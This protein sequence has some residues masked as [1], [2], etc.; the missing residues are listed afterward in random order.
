MFLGK[1]EGPFL[2]LRKETKDE[3]IKMGY[4]EKKIIIMEDIENDETDLSLDDKFRRI[5]KRH[6]PH[7]FI[8]FFPKGQRMD[9]V[10]FELGWLCCKYSIKQ[11][12][13]KLRFF[14]DANYGWNETTSYISSLFP[15]A[16]VIPLREYNALSTSKQIS[17][18]INTIINSQSAS[19]R[20]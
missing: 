6:N 13:H 4:K 7:L 8:A 2:E 10:T 14:A 17:N 16:N 5:L 18:W 20:R 1:G 9:G 3:L 15:Y 11:I 19:D 12:G